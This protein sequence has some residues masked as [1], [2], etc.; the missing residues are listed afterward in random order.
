[1]I[2]YGRQSIDDD[3]IEAV[4]QVL[5]SDFLTTGPQVAAFEEALC[6]VTGAAFAVACS[7][8][9]TALHLAALAAGLGSGDLAIVPTLTFLATAN[10]IRYTGA[11]VVFA[12]VDPETGLMTA[13][14][15]QNALEAARQLNPDTNRIKAALPVH[16]T[17]RSVNLIELDKIGQAHDIKIISDGCHALGGTLHGHQIGACATEDMTTFSFHP[18]K[19]IAMGEGGAVT[20]NNPEYAAA[21]RRLRH[22]GMTPAPEQGSWCYEMPELGFNHRLTDMQCALGVSQLKKLDRF[23]KRRTE[24]VALYNEQIGHLSPIV[25]PPIE[26]EYCEPAWHLYAVR[27]DFK[28]ADTTRAALMDA[29][30]EKGIGTQVHYIPVHTQPYYKKLYGEIDLPGAQHY[31]E[32]TL[33]LP[34]YPDMRDEDVAYVIETLTTILEK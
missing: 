10:A 9:T 24:L 30:K 17:G 1:M 14:T 31:Y 20:T 6:G 21:M 2:P 8:G 34:L 26:P 25:K 18:V 16:L 29:L 22:H 5:R 11:D 12:D 32:H 19:T 3:D 23:V 27:V 15:F 4:A 7:N 33:S 13:E 28:A